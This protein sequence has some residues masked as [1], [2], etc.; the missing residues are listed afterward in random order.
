MMTLTDEPNL[1]F[2]VYNIK[3]DA[4]IVVIENECVTVKVNCPTL[5]FFLLVYLF[6]TLDKK[7]LSRNHDRSP[8]GSND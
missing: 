4:S 2:P 1:H 6:Y 8:R 7:Y 5:I 3:K